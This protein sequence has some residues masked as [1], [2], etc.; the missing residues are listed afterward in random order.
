MLKKSQGWDLCI[1]SSLNWRGTHFL[2]GI[3]QLETIDLTWD[4]TWKVGC[5]S[6]NT[7]D[8]NTFLGRDS[9]IRNYWSNLRY[10]LKSGICLSSNTCEF[11]ANQIPH[12][13][14]QDIALKSF[15]SLLRYHALRISSTESPFQTFGLPVIC[16]V[17]S[18]SVVHMDTL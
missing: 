18:R 1:S 5:I 6:S 3:L 13:M 10:N 17:F 16:C 14:K 9:T 11:L 2:A 8:L 12:M 4:I 15:K 7:C